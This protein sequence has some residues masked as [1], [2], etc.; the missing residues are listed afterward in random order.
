[1]RQL[2][3]DKISPLPWQPCH[4]VHLRSMNKLEY[5][6]MALPKLKSTKFTFVKLHSVM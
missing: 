5:V 2:V 3:I 6:E 1:M 4:I